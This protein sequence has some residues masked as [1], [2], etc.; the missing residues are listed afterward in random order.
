[1][2]IKNKT[3]K[4]EDKFQEIED[5]KIKDY[6]KRLD[7]L[8][9]IFKYIPKREKLQ[10]IPKIFGKGHDEN[11]I[12]DYLAHIINPK[13]NG[14]GSEPLRKLVSKFLIEDK[15]KNQFRG[16]EI[17]EIN[18]GDVE[19]NREYSLQQKGKRGKERRIDLFIEIG[20]SFLVAI[21]NK[22]DSGEWTQGKSQTE[23]YYDLIERNFSDVFE[24]RIMVFLTP[25]GKEPIC[26][27]FK[28]L[29]YNKLVKLLK[30][31]EFDFA[32][33][34][35]RSF[36]YNDFIRHLEEY[37]MN[38]GSL[39]LN[40]KTQLFFEHYDIIEELKES[41]AEDQKEVFDYIKSKIRS[42]VINNYPGSNWN[43]YFSK[44]KTK[45]DYQQIYKEDWNESDYKVHFEFYYSLYRII[46]EKK[47]IFK[48][49][50]EGNRRNEFISIF[51]KKY[52]DV[53]EYEKNN[54]NRF[55]PK[56]K[57]KTI[58][59]KQYQI[60]ELKDLD[61]TIEDMLEDFL[62]LIPLIDQA[63]EDLEGQA[64]DMFK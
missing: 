20:D 34:I 48:V 40:E 8:N 62:F 13:K 49:D 29:S 28:A 1:L 52:Q 55:R 58:A 18:F 36:I 11:F 47:I 41:Y 21:E 5:K 15:S 31:V 12:S 35:R 64:N 61:K 9:E 57:D 51:R 63:I 38:K 50:V 23:I 17:E 44:L 59:Y 45:K 3:T 42:F 30:S 2:N 37:I 56:R 19:I 16:I 22:I 60:K 53:N 24:N 7:K 4:L 25:Q 27:E 39:E 26:E 33:D 46:S 43:F 32:D 14:I 10:T 54:V 6:K